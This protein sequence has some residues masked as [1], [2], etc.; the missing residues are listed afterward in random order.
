MNEQNE[1]TMKKI[2]HNVSCAFLAIKKS[3]K[4]LIES[5]ALN[6]PTRLLDSMINDEICFF[7]FE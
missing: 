4:C 3:L 7:D 5:K 6:G 1:I 2:P